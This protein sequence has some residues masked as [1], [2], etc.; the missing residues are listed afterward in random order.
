MWGCLVT[1]RARAG[2]WRGAVGLLVLGAGLVAMRA[3]AVMAEVAPMAAAVIVVAAVSTAAGSW[4]RTRGVR[5]ELRAQL[6]AVPGRDGREEHLQTGLRHAE[7][8]TLLLTTKLLAEMGPGRLGRWL[9]DQV[10]VERWSRSVVVIG[11]Q[12]EVM[13]RVPDHWSAEQVAAAEPMI[14]EADELVRAR[15]LDRMD[16]DRSRRERRLLEELGL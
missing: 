8:A 4:V 15:D 14:R 3:L 5:A 13:R 6:A 9:N 10:L 16:R 11:R 2:A 7:D 1:A 12:V